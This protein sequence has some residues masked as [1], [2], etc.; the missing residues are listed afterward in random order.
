M[1]GFNFANDKPL[2]ILALGAHCDDIE[3]GAGGTLLKI[4]DNY[5]IGTVKWVIF[6]SN[7]LRKK[8]A[9]AS[10]KMFLEG[11]PNAEITIHS[12]RDGFLPYLATEV[13]EAFEAIKQGFVPDVVFTLV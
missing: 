6:A 5:Q 11:I 3:L 1:L 10:A 2:N 9:T 8:E 13:K 12:Y 7:E 4:F